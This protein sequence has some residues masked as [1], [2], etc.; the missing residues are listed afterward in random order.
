MAWG[1][2][3][4]HGKRG[5]Q[6]CGE[7]LCP[8]NCCPMFPCQHANPCG[9]PTCA[10]QLLALGMSPGSRGIGVNVCPT[11]RDTHCTPDD[12]AAAMQ[13]REGADIS[14]STSENKNRGQKYIKH[15]IPTLVY[16]SKSM[17]IV[18]EIGI[19]FPPSE[20]KIFQKNNVNKHF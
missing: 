9:Q 12:I 1:S 11:D 14:I 18:D 16:S 15:S 5:T 2:K 13:A 8:I 6:P 7:P 3:R 4:I 10:S 17:Y 20:P 19:T